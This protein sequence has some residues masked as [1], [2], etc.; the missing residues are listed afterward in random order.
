MKVDISTEAAQLAADTTTQSRQYKR[1]T[2]KGTDKDLRRARD[3]FK[4]M[5]TQLAL[6]GVILEVPGVTIFD[7]EPIIMQLAE[8]LGEFKYCSLKQFRAVTIDWA[9]RQARL[10]TQLRQTER[11]LF[12]DDHI[13]AILRRRLPEFTGTDEEFNDWILATAK[14]EQ[15]GVEALSSWWT[16]YRR[17]VLRGI[18]KILWGCVDLG[19][20]GGLTGSESNGDSENESDTG[21]PDSLSDD[22]CGVSQEIGRAHV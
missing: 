10:V 14:Q 16:K 11:E 3:R 9:T 1:K 13:A 22:A 5:K 12:I 19:F 4:S 21:E 7:V 20:S 2:P 18:C 15:E 17:S 8:R 6:R